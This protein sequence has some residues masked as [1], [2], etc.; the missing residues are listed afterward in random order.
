ML[1]STL[2]FTATVVVLLPAAGQAEVLTPHEVAPSQVTPH[3]VMPT[4]PSRPAPAASS[5]PSPAPTPQPSTSEQA[6]PSLPASGQ[7]QAAAKPRKRRFGYVDPGTQ[8][9]EE[10]KEIEAARQLANAITGVGLPQ[11]PG[12]TLTLPNLVNLSPAGGE[13]LDQLLDQILDFFGLHLTYQA[14]VH[15]V[16]DTHNGGSSF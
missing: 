1:F 3:L 15:A 6:E 7:P 13:E 16:E 10:N 9:R 5:D 2:V 12:P 11:R 8:Q 4:G 14:G